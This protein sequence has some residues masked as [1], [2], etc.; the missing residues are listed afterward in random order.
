MKD[1]EIEEVIRYLNSNSIL[2]LTPIKLVRVYCPFSVRPM[3]EFSNIEISQLY[4]VTR[5]NIDRELQTVY[6]I[7]GSAYNAKYFLL[8]L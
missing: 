7:N 3:V 4:S 2:V 5:V 6:I 8:M 1:N